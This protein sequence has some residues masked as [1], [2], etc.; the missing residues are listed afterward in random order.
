MPG[1]AP[2][3]AEVD[4]ATAIA[5][6]CGRAAPHLADEFES[7]ALLGLAKAARGFDPGRGVRFTT[8]AAPVVLGAIKD[9][10]RRWKPR[11]FKRDPDAPAVLPLSGA[12]PDGDPVDPPDPEALPVG[13]EAEHA[14]EVAGLAQRLAPGHR[15]AFVAAF[16]HTTLAAAGRAVGLSE[17]RVSQILGEA[18]EILGAL[19]AGPEEVFM[20]G[21]NGVAPAAPP[22]K[23]SLPPPARGGPCPDCGHPRNPKNNRCYACRPGGPRPKAQDRPAAPKKKAAVP[24]LLER[25]P[26]VK[27]TPAPAPAPERPR[28]DL[29]ER[30]LAAVRT[31]YDALAAL[32][33]ESA[34]WVLQTVGR[35]Y[36][37]NPGGPDEHD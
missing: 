13:H 19:F 34:A 9:A 4:F 23:P 35:H 16:E 5:R 17:S 1:Y 32:P 26:R 36:P 3:Q 20:R 30:E 8:Y 37:L 11:G 33:E 24:A 22:P 12:D 25:T 2:S 21:T 18:V 7:A 10:A 31:V 15:L 14:D 29:L 27:A 28:H 6:G